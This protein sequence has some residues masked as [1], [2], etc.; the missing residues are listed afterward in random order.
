MCYTGT[1]FCGV[2]VAEFRGM[3]TKSYGSMDLYPALLR[4]EDQ[5]DV[6]PVS[7]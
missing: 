3:S 4:L 1:S 6:F 5:S 7:D 2:E